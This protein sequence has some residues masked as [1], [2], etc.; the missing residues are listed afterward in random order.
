[1]S[2][3]LFPIS[4]AITESMCHIRNGLSLQLQYLCFF[5]VPASGRI[6]TVLISVYFLRHEKAASESRNMFQLMF[7]RH[8]RTIAQCALSFSVHL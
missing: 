7:I 8:Y 2:T 4:N 1:M 6:V 3:D 5:Q